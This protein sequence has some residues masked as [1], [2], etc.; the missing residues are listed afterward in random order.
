MLD[1]F[2]NAFRH[3]L[4]QL[5]D[6]LDP[7][8]LAPTEHVDTSLQGI[9]APETSSTLNPNE[10]DPLRQHNETTVKDAFVQALDQCYDNFF[11]D[12]TSPIPAWHV[13]PN[14]KDVAA[15]RR[16]SSLKS[17]GQ[18]FAFQEKETKQASV[19]RT[20]GKTEVKLKN[21]PRHRSYVKIPK[22]TYDALTEL[23]SFYKHFS[24]HDKTRQNTFASMDARQR[25]LG[26]LHTDLSDAYER[27]EGSHLTAKQGMLEAVDHHV[28]VVDAAKRLVKQQRN[29]H[30][31][32]A[33]ANRCTRRD[34][35]LF[36][37]ATWI[38]YR[39]AVL[40]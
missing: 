2:K 7:S 35:R 30:Q 21:D 13:K 40:T 37:E 23:V 24:E 20:A 32:G 15:R 33:K 5:Y 25:R 26:V 1:D 18:T 6:E 8:S 39:G 38:N 19:Q 27:V 10:S 14:L 34:D 4:G 12:Q 9:K 3:A 36:S 28:E 31:H 11:D 17:D 29:D 22:A 16:S